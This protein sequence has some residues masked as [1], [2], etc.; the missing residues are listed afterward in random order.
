MAKLVAEVR[1]TCSSG[2][3]DGAR[4]I[5]KNVALQRQVGIY[6]SFVSVLLGH[7]VSSVTISPPV[8]AWYSA[9]A[10]LVQTNGLLRLSGA[11]YSGNF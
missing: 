3:G 1:K 8:A 10:R 5:A 2:R 6:L 9:A 11:G 4:M 7:K